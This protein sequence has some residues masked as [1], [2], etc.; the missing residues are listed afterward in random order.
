MARVGVER[1]LCVRVAVAL[2]VLRV[3]AGVAEGKYSGDE[4]AT[5]DWNISVSLVRINR[6]AEGWIW[7]LPALPEEAQAERS[8]PT[9]SAR[10]IKLPALDK[11]HL[12]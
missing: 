4:V 11:N 5:G 2:G 7:V 3:G 6:V 12:I 8:A 10:P 1:G 9:S